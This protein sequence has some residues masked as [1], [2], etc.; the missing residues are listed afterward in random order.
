MA[1]QPVRYLVVGPSGFRM[2]IH[3]ESRTLAVLFSGL[4]A[5]LGLAEDLEVAVALA[6]AE[7]RALARQLL[8]MADAIGGG[9]NSE[10]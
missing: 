9:M 7:A 3:L 5:E 1:D 6:P 10:T 2:S 8:D 4:G